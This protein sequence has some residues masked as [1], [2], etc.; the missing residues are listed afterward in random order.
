[1]P[2]FESVAAMQFD[3]VT[4]LPSEQFF[5]DDAGGFVVGS[6]Q[7]VGSHAE[8]RLWLSLWLHDTPAGVSQ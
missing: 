1:M 5:A 7:A 3:A 4:A 8:S 6:G 2:Y